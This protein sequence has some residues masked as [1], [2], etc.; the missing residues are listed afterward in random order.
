MRH[1][2]LVETI[3]T[4]PLE[5]QAYNQAW[6]STWLFP[7]L[8]LVFSALQ[9]LC[10]HFYNER[11]HPM[12]RILEEYRTE[13]KLYIYKSPCSAHGLRTPRG[14]IVFTALPKIHSHSQI[15]RYASSIFCLPHRPNF[16]DIFDLCLHWV[17]VV[18]AL[19]HTTAG[20]LFR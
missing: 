9:Y 1:N 5:D 12:A 4:L 17:S 15:F 3:G 2:F 20:R 8:T 6:I 10:F 18:R 19:D 14:E 7:L 13:G 16:S 11:Y